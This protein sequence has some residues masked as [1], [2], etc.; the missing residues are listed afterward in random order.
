MSSRPYRPPRLIKELN[1]NQQ[2]RQGT[3]VNP[4]LTWD[5]RYPPDMATLS[6]C[7]I[8]AAILDSPATQP[9]VSKFYITC[10]LFPRWVVDVRN[11]RGV[12]VRD[13]LLAV[14][15]KLRKQVTSHEF[16]RLPQQQQALIQEAAQWRIR[17]SRNSEYERSRGIRR[18]DWLLK[19]TRFVG[20]TP[21]TD[22]PY[23]WTLVVKR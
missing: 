2:E 22:A 14:Y 19:T 3:R 10:A 8:P 13:V 21:S 17:H 18:I 4:P 15:D 7:A 12:T 6:H 23:T 20:L 5:L 1:F 16:Q 9:P 11:P